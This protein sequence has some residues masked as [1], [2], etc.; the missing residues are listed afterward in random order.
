[1]MGLQVVTDVAR[2]LPGDGVHVVAF[3][4]LTVHCQAVRWDPAVSVFPM[5][6]H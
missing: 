2:T 1:M 6:T 4:R 3:E 5:K